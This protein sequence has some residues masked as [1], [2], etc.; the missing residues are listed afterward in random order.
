MEFFEHIFPKPKVHVITF[1]N[2]VI[3]YLGS[4]QSYYTKC[5]FD[6]FELYGYKGL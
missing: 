4:D 2:I 6:H 3:D 5:T 1:M